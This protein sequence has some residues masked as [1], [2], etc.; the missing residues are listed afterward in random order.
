MKTFTVTA[1]SKS[2]PV[3]VTVKIPT[4]TGPIT[5]EQARSA[6]RIAFGHTSGV[7][8]TDTENG[9]RLNGKNARKFQVCDDWS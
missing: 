8:V 6:A 5:P 9:Y 1:G 7:V 2:N 4:A 3:T